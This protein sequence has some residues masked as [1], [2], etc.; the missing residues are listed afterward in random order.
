LPFAVALSWDAATTVNQITCHKLL[1][2]VFDEVFQTLLTSGLREKVA[3]FGGCFS[4]RSQ[5]TGSKLSTH[6][7][8]IAVDLNPATNAQGAAGDMDMGV[9]AIFQKAGFTWGGEWEGRSRDPMHFQ[10]CSGY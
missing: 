9:I 10:F 3:T 2:K 4:F 8:G 5:R 1:V 7:W 6:A